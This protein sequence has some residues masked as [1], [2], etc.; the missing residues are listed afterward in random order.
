MHPQEDRKNGLTRLYYN[1]KPA[2][3]R[4]TQLAMR[5]LV[6]FTKQPRVR[7]VWPIDPRSGSPPAGWPGWPDGR[8]FALVLTHDVEAS[9]GQ[10]RVTALSR[11]EEKLGVR[12]SFNFVPRRYKVSEAL[13]KD[14]SARGFE[15][16]VH[17]LTHDGRL[18][19]SRSTFMSRAAQINQVLKEWGAVGFRSPSMHHNLDWLH[20][21][22]VSY[23]ASTFDTDPF[24]PQPD[25]LGTIFPKWIEANSD[26]PGY[27]ELPYTLPQDSTLFLIMGARS[28]DIWKQKLA[29]IAERGGMALLNTH[30]DYMRFGP[31]RERG[32]EYHSEL[33]AEFVRHAQATYANQYWA[34]LPREVAGYVRRTFPAARQERASA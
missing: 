24:E 4:A 12:S 13:R 22:Q 11:L 19:E 10:A 15:V 26:G 8:R 18:Y 28:I 16:G 14:L 32:D 17:G 5:R 30:P 9:R 25:G 33:Y 7:D 29:W 6:F 27:V 31:G 2:L 20:A 21:L 3:P 1:L 34:A 23:D